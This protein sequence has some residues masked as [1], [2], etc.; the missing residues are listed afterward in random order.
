[1]I[2]KA[3]ELMRYRVASIQGI[4]TRKK[5]EDAYFI[6][7]VLEDEVIGE[8]GLLFVVADGMG[9][10]SDGKVASDTVVEEVQRAYLDFDLNKSLP[11]QLTQALYQANGA[12]WNKLKGSGGSTAVLGLI[13]NDHLYFSSVGDSYIWIMHDRIITRM[14]RSHNDLNKRR[15]ECFSKGEMFISDMAFTNGPEALT[16]FIGMPQLLGTDTLLQPLPLEP[17]DTILFCSDGILEA[18]QEREL[19]DSLFLRNPE[20][21][22]KEID[23][24]IHEKNLQHQDNYTAIIV[25][26]F[27]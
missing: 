18:L 14:N 12:V 25:Q 22:C 19:E 1:M 2:L 10:M 4:G 26:C 5:Q 15:Q 20:E 16:N 13:I 24:R 6:S 7:E 11:E 27:C 8:K 17:G 21:M 23:I 9:G 3:P